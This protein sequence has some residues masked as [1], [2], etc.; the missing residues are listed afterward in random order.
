MENNILDLFSQ[1]AERYDE[2]TGVHYYALWDQIFEKIEIRPAERILD[3]GSGTGEI[4]FKIA[5]KYKDLTLQLTGVDFSPA[6]I[7][8]ANKKALAEEN[9]L[10]S[11]PSFHCQDLIDYLSNCQEGSCDLVL[12]SF[13]L[14]YVNYS[15]LFKL[16]NKVLNKGGKFIIL[17]TPKDFFKKIE[18]M[19]F[20][21]AL[22]HPFYINW[23]ELLT[24]KFSLTPSIEE[25]TGLLTKDHFSK[26]ETNKS[27]VK[28]TFPDPLTCVKWMDESGMASLY[29]SLIRKGKKDEAMEAMINYLDKKSMRFEGQPIKR[30]EPLR[31]DWEIYSVVAEK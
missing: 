23:W 7:S 5:R 9:R 25:I 10:V 11:R 12:I 31:F 13:M 27:T 26:I 28:I 24:K 6:M 21:F 2:I 14:A 8:V 16:V 19:F 29:L 22:S 30:G 17:T 4:L 3:L 15:E 1:K 18:N 20:N